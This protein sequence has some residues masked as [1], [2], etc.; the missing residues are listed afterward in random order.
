MWCLSISWLVGHVS[1]ILCFE[2]A[3]PT[4]PEVRPPAG[5]TWLG[6]L[7]PNIGGWRASSVHHTTPNKEMVK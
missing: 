6:G 2:C 7:H 1:W 3:S 5:D 4:D